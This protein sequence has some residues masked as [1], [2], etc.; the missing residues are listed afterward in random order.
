MSKLQKQWNARHCTDIICQYNYVM[1]CFSLSKLNIHTFMNWK[2]MQNRLIFTYHP[3]LI[4]MHTK[5]LYFTCVWGRT[6][7]TD[8]YV[9]FGT[10]Q[11]LAN[12]L[13]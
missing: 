7:A 11:D 9:T 4:K 10:A 3:L 1:L 8:C 13:I 2:T 12:V 6:R 5:T